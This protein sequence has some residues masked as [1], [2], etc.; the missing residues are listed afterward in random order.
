MMFL[1]LFTLP[2]ATSGAD[3]I[4]VQT[5]SIVPSFTPLLLT[6]VFFVVFLGGIARQLNRTGGADYA[7]WATVA[8][9]STFTVASI[10]TLITGLINLEW[11]VIVLVVT[12]FSGT[13]LFLSRKQS[14]V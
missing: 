14:E 4:L 12:I 3:T 2:N 7:M 6:F 9:L 5:A 8:S 13:W 10:L 1:E 11:F